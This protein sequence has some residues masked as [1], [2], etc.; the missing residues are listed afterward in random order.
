MMMNIKELE[1]KV[2]VAMVGAKRPGNES[3]MLQNEKGYWRPAH[4]LLSDVIKALEA[5]NDYRATIDEAANNTKDAE[6]RGNLLNAG[7]EFDNK[8]N[9]NNVHLNNAKR[10]MLKK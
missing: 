4:E 8:L 10:V 5:I 6:L 1:M 7:M 9:T 3:I 2:R